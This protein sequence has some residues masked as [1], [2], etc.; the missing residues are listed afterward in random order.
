LLGVLDAVSQRKKALLVNKHNAV[1]CITIS[2]AG[3]NNIWII[4]ENTGFGPARMESLSSD[5]ISLNPF[6]VAVIIWT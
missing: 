1:N 5:N 2:G 4:D 3:G 6:A